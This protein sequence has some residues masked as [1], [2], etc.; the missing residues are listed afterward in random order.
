M[1]LASVQSLLFGAKLIMYDGSPFIP[2]VD[3]FLRIAGEHKYVSLPISKSHP[4]K[5]LQLTHPRVTHL[6][7][8]PRY[9]STLQA[10]SIHPKASADLS[11][12]KVVTSTGMVLPPSLF[13]YFYSDT[14]FPLHTHLANISGGTD[15]AGAFGDSV[16]ILP[17]YSTGGCQGLSLGVDVRVFDSTVEASGEGGVPVGR[18]VGEGEPGDLVAVKVSFSTKMKPFLHHVSTLTMISRSQT[19]RSASGVTKGI[20]STCLPTSP[21]SM[22]SGHTEISS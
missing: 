21:A 15:L 7:I 2:H 18:E 5:S 6:G 20:R 22:V 16:P 8:S 3:T 10:A 9:L 1:Y 13:Q 11:A 4:L 19:C 12:L 17:V 14:G